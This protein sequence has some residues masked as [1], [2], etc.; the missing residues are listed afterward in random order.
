MILRQ[1][2][3]SF[4]TTTMVKTRT[5]SNLGGKGNKTLSDTTSQ[6]KRHFGTFR[7]IWDILGHSR[8]LVSKTAKVVFWAYSY[9]RLL[10]SIDQQIII[11]WKT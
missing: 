7:D 10:S 5:I 4:A 3:Q 6:Q 9:E 8:I 2:D 11:I 1:W